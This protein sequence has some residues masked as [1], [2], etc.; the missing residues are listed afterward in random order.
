[1]EHILT[2]KYLLLSCK[3]DKNQKLEG[4]HLCSLNLAVFKLKIKTGLEQK[5]PGQTKS[6][7]E[8]WC[9]ILKRLSF[10]TSI[11]FLTWNSIPIDTSTFQEQGMSNVLENFP[12]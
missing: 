1:M 7:G 6:K 12:L 3:K 2:L 10:C 9:I 4:N 8:T 5:G 11:A